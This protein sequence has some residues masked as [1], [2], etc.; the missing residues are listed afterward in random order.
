MS[1]GSTK[2]ILYITAGVALLAAAIGIIV[3]AIKKD[4]GGDVP[5]SCRDLILNTPFYLKVGKKYL[6]STAPG[7]LSE[8][9]TT[10]EQWQFRD[11][12]Y[13]KDKMA[14]VCGKIMYLTAGDVAGGSVVGAMPKDDGPKKADTWE[15]FTVE[16]LDASAT[17]VTI[18]SFHGRYL[19]INAKG[20]AFI[21][22]ASSVGSNENISLVKV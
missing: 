10:A 16:C 8:V 17:S 3:Y 20:T 6:S 13:I 15:S 21:N 18:K 22:S 5:K 19:G 12:P 7:A 9:A 14:L 1:S 11:H 4:K 2:K